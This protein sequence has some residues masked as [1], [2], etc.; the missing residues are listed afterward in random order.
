[1]PIDLEVN[2]T[3]ILL[4]RNGVPGLFRSHFYYHETCAL[5]GCTLPRE[6]TFTDNERYC[7]LGHKKLS[8]T[9]FEK[10][11]SFHVYDS[12]NENKAQSDEL[13]YTTVMLKVDEIDVG[14]PT[15]VT[16]SVFTKPLR[17]TRTSSSS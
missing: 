14:I 7:C 8:S 12:L 1:M 13:C 17:K 5:V 4:K 9:C 16:S 15:L 11:A 10:K 3:N 2:L 6:K